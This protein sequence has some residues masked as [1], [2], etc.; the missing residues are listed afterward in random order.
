MNYRRVLIARAYRVN[1]RQN[2]PQSASAQSSL[3]PV[4]PGWPISET[5][6]LMPNGSCVIGSIRR[7]QHCEMSRY[8]IDS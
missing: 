2:V 6:M 3:R 4:T 7:F 8:F 1:G 5:V